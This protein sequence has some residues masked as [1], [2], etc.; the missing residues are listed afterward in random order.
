MKR[1]SKTRVVE[2]VR[3]NV[4]TSAVGSGRNWI[5]IEVPSGIERLFFSQC[6]PSAASKGHWKYDFFH[7]I[8]IERMGEITANGATMILINYVDK[9]FSVLDG[10]DIVWL[11]THSSRRRND[12]GYVCDIV[13]ERDNA[14]VYVL[15]PYDRMKVER[16][17]VEVMPW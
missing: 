12:V 2:I 11:C 14:G 1:L 15:R 3:S 13:I 7:T 8:S 6:K 4:N 10:E 17:K 16:R 9:V 5:D